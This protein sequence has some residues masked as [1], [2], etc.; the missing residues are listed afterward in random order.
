MRQ[1]YSQE[2]SQSLPE[3]ARQTDCLFLAGPDSRARCWLWG[4]E[5]LWSG[6]K[7]NNPEK[8]LVRL[9]IHSSYPPQRPGAAASICPARRL[10]PAAHP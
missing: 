10:P 6:S 1:Y 4:S 8:S 5:A 9:F 2:G 3:S 7:K